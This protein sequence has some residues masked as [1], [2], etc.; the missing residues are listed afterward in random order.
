MTRHLSVFLFLFLIVFNSSAQRKKPQSD[1]V[2]SFVKT[3]TH[4]PGFIDF[5]WDQEKDQIYLLIKEFN[6]EVIYINSL[7]AGV[8]SN[9]I[10]L[11]RGQLGQTRIV[12]FERHG[13]KVFLSQP[14]YRYRAESENQA[15]V[16]A[17]KD[18]F[19]VSVIWGFKVEKESPNGV[20]I[21]ATDFFIRDAHGVTAR[22]ARTKQGSYSLDKTRSAMYEQGTLNFPEN[23][24]FEAILTFTGKA[25]GAYV[26]SVTPTASSVTV[27]QHHSFVKLPD[28]EYT[29]REHDPRAG[30][31][32]I[33]YYDYATPIDQPLVKRYISRHRLKKKDPTAAKSEPVEPI[34]YYLD[35]GT[36]EPVRSALLD[37][38][39]WWNQ[40]F[41]DAGYINAFRVEMLPE[42]AHPLDVR[43]NVIQWIHRSTRGWSYGSSVRDP[44]TGEIIKGH[45]SLGSLRVRQDFL[46]AEG[47]LSPYATEDV[48]DD[49]MEMALARIRQLSAHE[50]GHTIGLAH[51]YA[52]STSSRASVMD[53]P[54]PYVKLTNGNIDLSEAYDDKIGAWDKIAISY[55]YSDF[56]SEDKSKL[57]DILLKAH[58]QGILFISDRDARAQGGAHPDAHLWD[59][60]SNVSDELE[61]VMEV[62]KVALDNFSL[63]NIREGEPYSNLEDR[64]VPV[65]LFHRYQLEAAV[66]LI[67]GEKYTYGVKGQP[68][69]VNQIIPKADQEQ[70]LKAVLGTLSPKQ[71]ALNES[72]VK[73]IPPMAFGYSRSRESFE[74]RTG[75]TFDAISVAETAANLTLQLL[76][77]PQR[78]S[79][80]V[81]QYAIDPANL[82]LEAVLS[83]MTEY[84]WKKNAGELLEAEVKGPSIF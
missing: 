68:E 44:R 38:A 48:P 62:R 23:S 69:F 80:L 72:I 2:E 33:S 67:G 40:A 83:A 13:P 36:P 65:Y 16:K 20:L 21:N 41:E 64:L 9:D 74:H 1:P 63:N 47:L 24:E 50:V 79:R 14:N 18:A 43:Y 75:L 59:N 19:A 30:F 25:E 66:K 6:K 84:T 15:E 54:H 35:P 55:G 56:G 17:V 11:D 46:I 78:A 42:D 5:F 53:Y 51:N 58:D 7:A 70:A 26:Q 27:R 77:N 39:R 31:F 81:E 4:Y 45:V 49:M 12:S 60:G 32:G 29:P 61:R 10:G 37:G 22:L 8:G 82:G 28:D 34:I 57:N 73:L 3:F 76:L 71:L 52:A